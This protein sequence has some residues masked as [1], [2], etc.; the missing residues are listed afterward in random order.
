[1]E[2]GEFVNTSVDDLVNCLSSLK[3]TN[4]R[5][6]KEELEKYANDVNF[7][8]RNSSTIIAMRKFHNW[9]KRQLIKEVVNY[10]Y[11]S[12]KEDI[13]LLDIAV[14]RGGDIDKWD[15]A[16]V[17]AVFGFDP[18]SE[19]IN[20]IDPFNPGAKTRLSKLDIKV[21]V[22]LEIGNA[23]APSD[24]LIRNIN[25]F[26]ITNK[27][28][29]FQ[30][31]LTFISKYLKKGGFFIGTTMD[32]EKIKTLFKGMGNTK[33]YAKNPL[34]SIKRDFIA[35][36]T[37]PYNNKYI[38]KINDLVDSGNYFNTMGES[39]EYLVDFSELTRVAGTVGLEPVNLNFFETYTSGSNQVY[40]N[41]SHIM[42]FGELYDMRKWKPKPKPL[43]EQ[44]KELNGLYS[45]FVFRK[46]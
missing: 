33:I 46:N 8:R 10:Y 1:M 27:T 36:P 43:S 39:T 12:K 24:E 3:T 7:K 2:M 13:N 37:S 28:S 11:T 20:S 30:I 42:P 34:F 45:T 31:V 6:A 29:A 15:E 41:H 17:S 44:E 40:T 23:L 9:V 21:K 35:K 19:S 25:T 14:G 4:D 26:L 22:H 32:S 16:Y 5:N 18:S 38:F